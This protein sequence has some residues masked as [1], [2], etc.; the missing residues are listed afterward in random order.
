LFAADEGY[1]PLLPAEIGVSQLVETP[2][3]AESTYAVVATFMELSRAVCVVAVVPFGNTDAALKLAADPVVFAALFG[4]SPPTSG[5][6]CACAKIPVDISLAVND[7]FPFSACPF[8][9]VVFGT[10]P[11]SADATVAA[12]CTWLGLPAFDD[13]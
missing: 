11:A 7:T 13:I 2:A 12:V 8:T 6:N 5:G 4:I 3:I 9:D 10:Y 1:A